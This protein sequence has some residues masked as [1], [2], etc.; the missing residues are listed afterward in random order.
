MGRQPLPAGLA[1]LFVALFIYALGELVAS[2]LAAAREMRFLRWG[3]ITLA[4]FQEMSPVQGSYGSS[5]FVLVYRVLV[6]GRKVM[7]AYF[8]DTEADKTDRVQLMLYD[9]RRPEQRRFTARMRSENLSAFGRMEGNSF[10]GTLFVVV[11]LALA[12]LLV[13]RAIRWTVLHQYSDS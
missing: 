11:M 13:F 10:G 6:R 4:V 5:F 2:F 1:P 7:S 3:R 8:K 9:P 12:L